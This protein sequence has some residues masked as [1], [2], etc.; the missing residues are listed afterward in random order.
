MKREIV[1]NEKFDEIVNYLKQKL[2]LPPYIKE[3]TLKFTNDKD[4][5][6]TANFIVA[7]PKTDN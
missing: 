7:T 6:I 3:M 1:T 5:E 2:D 4:I